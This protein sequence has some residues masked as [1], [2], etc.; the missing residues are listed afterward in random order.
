MRNAT[1]LLDARV[2]VNL[3]PS[4][5]ILSEWQNRIKR[6]KIPTLRTATKQQLRLVGLILHRHGLGNFSTKI[7]F[8]A[9]LNQPVDILLGLTFID[10]NNRRI[11]SLG[12]NV[13]QRH[14][15][16]VAIFS[17]KVKRKDNRLMES[18]KKNQQRTQNYRLRTKNMDVSK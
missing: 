9:A 15:Q 4:F 6:N 18:Q 16:P 7:W 13:L 17:R 3:T 8:G 12:R 11:L 14:C 1:R 10:R 2:G 5:M